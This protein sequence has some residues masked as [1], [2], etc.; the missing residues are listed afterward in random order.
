[1]NVSVLNNIIATTI[2]MATPLML[3]ALGGVF[4]QKARVFNIGLEGLMLM[5]SFTAI[6]GVMLTGGSAFAGL[7]F[8][9][10]CCMVFS[11]LFYL[12]AIKLHANQIITGIGI[13]LMSKGLTAFLLRAA[14]GTKGTLR[15][16]AMHALL[17]V[18][19][20]FLS[21]V[22]VLGG[23][24]G[25]MHILAILAVCM[26][27]VTVVILRRTTIG[28]EIIAI[29]EMPHA[30]STA[31]VKPDRVYLFAIL[32]SGALCAVAGAYLSLVSVGS[33]T[34]DMVNGR[35]FTAFSALIFGNANPYAACAVSLL[36]GFADAL[37]IKLELS[38]SVIPSSIVKMFPYLLAVAALAF[39]SFVSIRRENHA[40][41]K[42]T[43]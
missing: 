2:R 22:P 14:F 11:L 28:A 5:G 24:F 40:S 42:K 20:P 35:G 15:P 18:K 3:A 34:E 19:L 26:M 41:G 30:V 43:K 39:S 27:I 8:A 38:N 21:K 10:V 31:G 23:V 7:L 33:F 17:S 4:C 9:V 12:F 29:G 36:F 6:W 32:W 1:M 25:E 16:K 13:N 37:G